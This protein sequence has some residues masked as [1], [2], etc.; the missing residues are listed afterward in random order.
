MPATST[1]LLTRPRKATYA[2]VLEAPPHKVAEIIDGTLYMHARPAFRH[3]SA[4]T[5]LGAIIVRPFHKG[6]GGP[7]GWLVAGEPELHLGEGGKDVLVPDFAGWR[8]ECYAEG[9]EIAY[10]S[11]A[12]DWACEVLSPSIRNLD[13]GRKSDIYAHVGVSY[14]WFIDPV[15]RTL[16]AHAMRNG[17]W[18]RIANLRGDA[19]ASVPPFDVIPFHLSE[20]WED[21]DWATA[22][23]NK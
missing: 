7:G 21:D 17:I 11:T 18:K 9:A 5:N 6:I 3:A 13:L 2:N 19:V 20:R 4:I 8:R 1:D 16:T 23:A 15:E 10:F 14:L 12:P 22:K